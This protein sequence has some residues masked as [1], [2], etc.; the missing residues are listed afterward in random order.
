MGDKGPHSPG[1]W[2]EATAG[3][4][5]GAVGTIV[6]WIDAKSKWKVDFGADGK[7]TVRLLTLLLSIDASLTRSCEFDLP[8]H[9]PPPFLLFRVLLSCP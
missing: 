5:K 6:E 7:N 3:S 9:P 4:Q 1:D 8:H 2:V